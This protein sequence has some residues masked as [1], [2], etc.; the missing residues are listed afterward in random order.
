MVSQEPG[1]PESEKR[2]HIASARGRLVKARV[3]EAERQDQI[4]GLLVS[5]KS[6]ENQNLKDEIILLVC[7]DGHLKAKSTR[8]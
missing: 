2:D 6:Q 5:V 1:V 4:T 3:P 7:Q 8:I